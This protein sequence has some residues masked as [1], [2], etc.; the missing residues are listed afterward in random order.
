M[1]NNLLFFIFCLIGMC[2]EAQY[3]ELPNYEKKKPWTTDV[4]LIGIG[5]SDDEVTMTL[6]ISGSYNFN[7][8]ACLVFTNPADG[9]IQKVFLKDI[10]RETGEYAMRFAS[11]GYDSFTLTFP[12]LPNG[13]NKI[14]LITDKVQVYGI[15]IR[16][17]VR[18]KPKQ[19]IL[20]ANTEKEIQT[21]VDNTS[22]NIAGFYESL[23]NGM[24]YAVL[25]KDNSIYVVFVKDNSEENDFWRCGEVRGTLR[26]TSSTNVYK[27]TWLLNNKEKQDALIT[28]DATSM[29]L[30]AKHPLTDEMVTVVFAKMGNSNGSITN[31]KENGE[32]WTGTGF[33]LADGYLVTNYHVAGEATEIQIKGVNGDINTGYKAELVASDKVNDIAI[34][35]IVDANFKGFGNIPYSISSSMADV[36]VDVFVLGYPLTQALGNE[37]KLT[38]GI[39]SSRTGYQGNIATYQIS[40]PIQPGNSGGPMFDSKGN[41]IGVVVAGV[42]GAENVGYAIKT[43]YLKILIESA[44][45]NIKFPAN[46]TLSA[47]SLAEKVKRVKNFVFYIECSNK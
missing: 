43:T 47:L 5:T 40:A 2:A 27:A 18:A 6:A 45:L 29:S 4:K 28:F 38:N 26:P 30:N 23:E 25:Q 11:Y 33:A 3:T 34:V 14:D 22:L 7:A 31:S 17:V 8:G 39:V 46:N 36:G 37:I 16:P 10:R 42:P 24:T 19:S 44:G 32:L 1:R 13:V 12:P 20:I 15:S 9:T 21:L 35:R 41:V